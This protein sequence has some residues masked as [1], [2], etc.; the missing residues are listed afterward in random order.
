MPYVL[1]HEGSLSDTAVAEDDDLYLGQRS[2]CGATP[3]YGA[4]GGEVP[5]PSA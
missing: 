4:G 2:C 3:S 5:V 1:V